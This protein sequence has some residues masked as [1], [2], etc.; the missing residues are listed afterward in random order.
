MTVD[1]DLLIDQG[2]ICSPFPVCNQCCL[3]RWRCPICQKLCVCVCALL[4]ALKSCL[5]PVLARLKC[6]RNDTRWKFCL[7]TA[8]ESVESIRVNN[9]CCHYFKITSVHSPASCFA[10]RAYFHSAILFF[11]AYWCVLIQQ[12]FKPSF[13]S[14][15]FH[16]QLIWVL[17]W[18]SSGRRGLHD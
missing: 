10:S 16:T 5:Q 14:V 2:S 11:L 4:L 7:V 12:G 13:S 15:T 3:A 1:L 9:L 17:L 8:K 18:S 6:P